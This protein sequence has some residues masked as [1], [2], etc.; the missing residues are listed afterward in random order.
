MEEEGL[1]DGV[2]VLRGFRS[3]GDERP[4]D[5]TAYL[6]L[7][8]SE[9]FAYTRCLVPDDSD[10]FDRSG[11]AELP[12]EPF[13]DVGGRFGLSSF[14]AALF[15][16]GGADGGFV[17]YEAEVADEDTAAV[18]GLCRMGDSVNTKMPF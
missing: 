17:V 16:F 4:G 14:L 12:P 9:S 2:G 6:E 11:E 5:D 8:V 3:V 10:A 18:I 7:H 1:F 15:G 13:F